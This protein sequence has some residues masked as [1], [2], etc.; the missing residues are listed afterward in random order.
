MSTRENWHLVFS[1]FDFFFR[2]VFVFIFF[3]TKRFVKSFAILI[4]END[5]VYRKFPQI[6]SSEQ[7]T[8]KNVKIRK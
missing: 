5:L 3:L 1:T 2:W 7:S 4:M 6:Q 8:K